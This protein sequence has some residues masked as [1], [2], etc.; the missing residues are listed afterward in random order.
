MFYKNNQLRFLII[1]LFMVVI[2][3]SCQDQSSNSSPNAT[4]NNSNFQLFSKVDNKVSG[5]DFSNNITE[6]KEKNY[7]NFE[8]I[9][10]GAGVSTG[11]INNDGLV[12]IYFVGNEVP[13]KLYLNQG[14]FKFKDITQAAGLVGSEGWQ[15]G[16]TMVDINHD[17]WLDIYVCAG[18]W[19]KDPH[20]RKN[21]LYINQKNSESPQFKELANEYGLAETGHSLQSSFFDYDNDGDLDVYITNHPIA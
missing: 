9:Y 3:V 11:D 5:I 15:N 12:D 16:V 18:G 2:L 13:N 20:K 4:Q 7:F 14:D 6:N 19:M 17:G 10:N 21:L 1:L 8:Y